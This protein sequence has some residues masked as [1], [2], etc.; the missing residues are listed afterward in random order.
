MYTYLYRRRTSFK[1]AQSTKKLPIYGDNPLVRDNHIIIIYHYH[2]FIPNMVC[3]NLYRSNS[4]SLWSVIV[5]L[6]PECLDSLPD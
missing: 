4:K 2:K 3:F 1:S 5:K 6:E